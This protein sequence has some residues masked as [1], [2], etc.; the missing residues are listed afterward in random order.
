MT[1]K[2]PTI[3]PEDLSIMAWIFENQVVSEK[4]DLLDFA[5]RMFLLDI[6][7]DWRQEIVIKKCAWPGWS[8]RPR[9]DADFAIRA[10]RPV[11]AND[12]VKCPGIIGCVQEP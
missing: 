8:S 10:K 6:L 11:M 1:E 12:P 7:T 9:K 4:G 2:K 5:D 3:K